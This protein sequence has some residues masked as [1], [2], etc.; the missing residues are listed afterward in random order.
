MIGTTDVDFDGEPG[1]AT[2]SPVETDYL[3][4][5]VNR[6]FAAPITRNDVV[7]AFAGV[8]PLYDDG[9]AAAQ[10]ATRDFV[11]DL[12]G[13]PNGPPLLNIYGGKIT[14]YRHL[15]EQ[16]LAKLGASFT[17]MGPAWTRGAVLP[18]GDFP[19]TG[20]DDLVATLT[21]AW[22]ALPAPLVRRLARA[23]GTR[24][25]VILDGVRTVADL[26]RHFGADLYVRELEHM[27]HSEWARTGDDALW[28][29]SKLGLR[30]TAAE[31]AAVKDWFES[32]ETTDDRLAGE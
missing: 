32:V 1:T 16:A 8:R 6:F 22:P 29:R 3:C 4:A 14:T 23:Y 11:L 30:L 26:G 10:Q 27:R 21:A 5:A 20:F 15:A 2:I 12:D 31:Q 25:R 19:A 17:A 9:A 28:R 13:D 24:T 18:G 7:A